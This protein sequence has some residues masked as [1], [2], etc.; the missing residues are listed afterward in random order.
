MGFKILVTEPLAQA[1][2]DVFEAHG[3]TVDVRLGLSP[4]E[5][6]GIIGGYDAL[7]VRSA[8]KVTKQLIDA[9]PRLKIVGRAGVGVDNI[10]IDAAS[11]AGVLVC[12]A[13]ESNLVSAAEHTMALMMAAA[14]KIPQAS[15]RL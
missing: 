2:I 6:A 1:G 7:I 3:S 9:A 5:L 11:E 13:P 15:A 4:E 14:R 12:N 8:T 10:D